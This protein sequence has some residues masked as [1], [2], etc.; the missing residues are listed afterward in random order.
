MNE[1]DKEL[2]KQAWVENDWDGY[3]SVPKLIAFIRADERDRM[4]ERF[5]LSKELTHEKAKGNET[6]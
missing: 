3:L 2:A 4:C 6:D 1:R 5:N